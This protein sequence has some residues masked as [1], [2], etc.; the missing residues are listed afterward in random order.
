[1]TLTSRSTATESTRPTPL[2]DGASGGGYTVK[3]DH[4]TKR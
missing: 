3:A 1:M 2:R 4:V